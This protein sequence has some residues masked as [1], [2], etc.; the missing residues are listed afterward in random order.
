MCSLELHQTCLILHALRI[1][2]PFFGA[3]NIKLG[4]KVTSMFIYEVP[5]SY[6]TCDIVMGVFR[7][8]AGFS[9][10]VICGF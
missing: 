8:L 10:V 5:Q 4:N 2:T 6:Y 3:S 9:F 1:K 7:V